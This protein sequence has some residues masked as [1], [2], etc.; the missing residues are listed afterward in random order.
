MNDS[1]WDLKSWLNRHID[2]PE[3]K[4]YNRFQNHRLTT[5][6]AIKMLN[7]RLIR[8]NLQIQSLGYVLGILHGVAELQNQGSESTTTGMSSST[9]KSDDVSSSEKRNLGTDNTP[10]TIIRQNSLFSG[11]I[12][13]GTNQF[14]TTSPMSSTRN[15]GGNQL[16]KPTRTQL[17]DSIISSTA[18]M[19]KVPSSSTMNLVRK[20]LQAIISRKTPEE[21]RRPTYEKATV[22]K[23]KPQ[24]QH[25]TEQ[26]NVS[27]QQIHKK[28]PKEVNMRPAS[29]SSIGSSSSSASLLNKQRPLGNNGP[30]FSKQNELLATRTSQEPVL[31]K[32]KFSTRTVHPSD[33]MN[34]IPNQVKTSDPS[35]SQTNVNYSYI[36]GQSTQKSESKKPKFSSSSNN[37]TN[38]SSFKQRQPSKS[39]SKE[40]QQIVIDKLLSTIFLQYGEDVS[41]DGSPVKNFSAVVCQEIVHALKHPPNELHQTGQS[42]SVPQQQ[43]DNSINGSNN[44]GMRDSEIETLTVLDIGC[45]TGRLSFELSSYFSDVIGIDF[46]S[47]AIAVASE[48]QQ[49]GKVSRGGL[50]YEFQPTRKTDQVIFGIANDNKNMILPYKMKMKT[51]LNGNSYSSNNNNNFKEVDLTHLD[52]IVAANVLERLTKPRKFLEDLTE[53]QIIGDWIFLT[54]T[55]NWSDQITAKDDRIGGNGRL[56]AMTDLTQFFKNNG[57]ILVKEALLPML[58]ARDINDSSAFNTLSSSGKIINKHF[59]LTNSHFTAWKRKSTSVNTH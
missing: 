14:P 30:L 36:T 22:M 45:Q 40:H 25:K 17:V 12:S 42:L 27:Q 20:D 35:K 8:E 43:K 51:L 15:S 52:I 4:I 48:M 46:D 29:T 33:P 23:Q 44:G 39:K 58:Q 38:G 19:G 59:F 10:N 37:I 21:L 26:V 32:P 28:R 31:K 2:D 13:N 6:S 41:L 53:R 56:A 49:L 47:K 3:G 54:S 7:E 9:L 55:Y 5:P 16:L 50:T 34:N 24:N 18:D 11:P 1:N 57:Y